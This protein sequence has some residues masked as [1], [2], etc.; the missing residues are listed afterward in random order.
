MSN[1]LIRR[2]IIR[3]TTNLKEEISSKVSINSFQG[4]KFTDFNKWLYLRQLAP[5]HPNK[6]SF[7]DMCAN[8][9]HYYYSGLYLM[10]AKE[11]KRI[12]SEV[13]RKIDMGRNHFRNISFRDPLEK[14]LCF[15]W[16]QYRNLLF[17]W[18][19]LNG[20]KF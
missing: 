2:L 17:D 20:Y 6:Y 18:I 1:S 15:C 7:G 3:G 13:L 4:K 10:E 8:I 16:C 14:N 12:K 19:N 11:N 9:I 5:R